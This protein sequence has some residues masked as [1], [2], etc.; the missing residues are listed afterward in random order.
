MR[1]NLRLQ[2]LQL[3][4]LTLYLL[5]KGAFDEAVNGDQ[6]PRKLLVQL[7]HLVDSRMMAGQRL[8]KIHHLRALHGMD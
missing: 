7:I 2:Q 6:H 3:K 4:L 8:L 1:I 5:R